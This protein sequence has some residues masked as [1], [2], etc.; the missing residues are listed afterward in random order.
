M[1]ESAPQFKALLIFA[2]HRY[3]GESLLFGSRAGQLQHLDYLSTEQ[4]LADYATLITALRSQ[5]SA[6]NNP[7]IGFGGSYGGMLAS[8]LRMK[9]PQVVDGVIAGSAPIMS[10]LGEDPAYDTGSYAKLVT[11]DATAAGGSSD[12]CA[13]NVRKAWPL[14]FQHGSTIE[15][16]AEL[17]SIFRLCP[18]SVL[19]SSA[20]V[21][22]LAYWL[23]SSMDYMSMGSYPFPSSYILNGHGELPAYPLRQMCKPIIEASAD[24]PASLFEALREGV[25]VFYNYTGTQQCFDTHGS[26]NNET[27]IDGQ[28]WD[29][30]FCAE[31]TQPMSRDGVHDMFFK[32]DFNLNATEQQCREQWGIEGQPYWANTLY[33]GWRLSGASNI[34][35][36]NGELDPWRGGGVT[37]NVSLARDLVA[38]IISDVG[39]H[40]D[41]MFSN[42][43]D[44]PSV[45]QA[46]KTER[47]YIAKWCD[48][49]HEMNAG[50]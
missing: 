29:Y 6:Q 30:L 9:Y 39:H 22:S 37:H 17:S 47:A 27:T 50:Q 35:W 4:A 31:M 49:F 20:D 7:I 10:F 18:N 2:E 32:Q 44:P 23:Q 1:W 24:A 48:N 12:D 26:A 41:L 11:F 16:R 5:L 21:Y 38:I 13:F 45:I 43:L 14:L 33:G 8:W 42:P 34:L 19:K 28:L 25:G 46:R 40:M 3:F 36:S 15:G